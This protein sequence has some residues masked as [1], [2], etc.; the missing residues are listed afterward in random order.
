MTESPGNPSGIEKPTT[1]F[2]E[3]PIG[4]EIYD[5]DGRLIEVNDHCLGIFGVHDASEIMGF[6]LFDDPNLPDEAKKKIQRGE[7]SR[8]QTFFDF[9]KVIEKKLYKTTKTGVMYIDVI[10]VPILVRDGRKPYGYIAQIQDIS[11][12]MRFEDFL[13]VQRDLG[14]KLGVSSNIKEALDSVL[15]AV[16]SV[17]GVDSAALYLPDVQ[18]KTIY[19]AA[20][21]GLSENF[22]KSEG[23]SNFDLMSPQARLAMAGE[24]VYKKNSEDLP[25][26]GKSLNEKIRAEGIHT[27][28]IIPIKYSGNIISTL[29]VGSRTLDE[30]PPEVKNT[31]EAITSQIGPVIARMRDR[32]EIEKSEEKFRILA[33]FTYDWEYWVDANGNYVY[34]SPS[35]E[36][37]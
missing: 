7:I 3:A 25:Y 26:V 13:R 11:G 4:I 33:D 12:K 28:A 24:P 1:V 27:L 2:D 35:C 23:F 15:E 10:I 5:V 30:F 29:D 18:K 31:L 32:A 8:Y 21:K 34:I 36:R 14:I 6:K 22:A 17:W 16:V 9:S 37:I 20:Q 19:L